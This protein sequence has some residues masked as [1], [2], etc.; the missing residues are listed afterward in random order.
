MDAMKKQISGTHYMHGEIGP[1]DYIRAQGLNFEEGNVI[2]YV[3]RY[4][5]KGGRADL[6]K[7]IHYLELLIEYNY[8]EEDEEQPILPFDDAERIY[9][10]I[11]GTD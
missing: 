1:I 5:Y 9:R 3:T 8:P 2:K 11:G 7:A 6:E 10:H 4:R